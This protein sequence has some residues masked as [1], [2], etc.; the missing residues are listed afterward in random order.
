VGKGGGAGGPEWTGSADEGAMG[1][2]NECAAVTAW[3]SEGKWEWG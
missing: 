2:E 1:G 3:W